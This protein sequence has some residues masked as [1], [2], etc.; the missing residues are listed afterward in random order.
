MVLLPP[1]DLL[2]QLPDPLLALDF[3]DPLVHLLEL[4]QFF[5][6]YFGAEVEFREGRKREV[7]GGREFG[8]VGGGEGDPCCVW[9]TSISMCLRASPV[10]RISELGVTY[11]FFAER[12]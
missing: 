6:E 10:S 4:L 7:D 1:L 12:A 2:N 3:V 9:T 8:R 11:A 5:G